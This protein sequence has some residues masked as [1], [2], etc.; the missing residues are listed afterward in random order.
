VSKMRRFTLSLVLLLAALASDGAAQGSCSW[1]PVDPTI[2]ECPSPPVALPTQEIDLGDGVK[3][4][5]NITYGVRGGR[6][7][8]GDLYLP[9]TPSGVLITVHG[10]GWIDCNRRRD[11]LSW[12]AH[13]VARGLQIA[14]F[15][16]DYRLLREGGRYPQNLGD[17]KCA[18]QFV[19]VNAAGY[20][21]DGER[22]GLA[23]ESAGAQLVALAAVTSGRSDLDPG[24]GALPPVP[25]IT[26]AVSGPMDLPRW[27]LDDPAY[28]VVL[29]DFLGDSCLEPV[30]GCDAGRSCNVC[31]DASPTAHACSAAGNMLIVHGQADPWVAWDQGKYFEGALLAAGK[32]VTA[33]YP[34]PE[35]LEA[36]GCDA[37]THGLG[38]SCLIKAGATLFE[39]A[40]RAAL[41]P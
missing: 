17:V 26:L 9:S 11:V 4:I 10:G 8:Q 41:I 16:I 14:T 3:L 33:L 21:L 19:A 40:L 12:Y 13:E 5:K 6:V 25:D 2:V 36:L 35:E 34:T 31:V 32:P 22:I 39:P 18:M 30:G 23:G 1:P 28:G 38:D 15:N 37:K 20:G 27:A 29:A 24:C 7:L